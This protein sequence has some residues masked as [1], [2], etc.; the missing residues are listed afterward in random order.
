MY[1]GKLLEQGSVES[2]FAQPQHL[3]TQALLASVP[4]LR[5]GVLPVLLRDDLPMPTD[6]VLSQ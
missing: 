2:V 5:G 6:L 4:R 3:Y 1:L